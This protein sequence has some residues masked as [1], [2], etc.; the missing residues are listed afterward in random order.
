MSRIFKHVAYSTQTTPG[1]V[2]LGRE[3][4]TWTRFISGDLRKTGT[5]VAKKILPGRLILELRRYR[6]FKKSERLLYLKLRITN[7]LG[8]D[9][10][11]VPRGA[12]SFVFV[13]FGN[14]MRSPMSGAL[15]E[16]AIARYPNSPVKI[17]SAG[18]NA[19]PGTPAH[20]WAIAAAHDFGISLEVHQATLLTRAMVDE[21]DA[22]LA[23]DFQNQVELLSRYPDAADRF[24][25]LGAYSG[26]SA[27]PIEIRDPFFGD[28]DETR[29][30]Y[31]LLQT[32]TQ[33]LA[34]GLDAVVGTQRAT[35]S[36]GA[37]H[38]EAASFDR[39]C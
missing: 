7:T 3:L 23:M 1:T 10:R 29:R 37:E 28:L 36:S 8:L 39:W 18:L 19:T 16:K 31:E 12:R 35:P 20:P 32:C 30:C 33:N 4:T 15:F 26:T 38:D 11:K 6:G 13:C 14:I 25:L 27:R 22:I 24:F 17:T 2:K 21:A 34:N 5:A 9:S